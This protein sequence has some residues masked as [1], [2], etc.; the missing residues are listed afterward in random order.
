MTSAFLASWAEDGLKEFWVDSGPLDSAH[1]VPGDRSLPTLLGLLV[2][3]PSHAVG[4]HSGP[5]GRVTLK[6]QQPFIQLQPGEK[7]LTPPLG[8]RR[9]CRRRS[10]ST[11]IGGGG[12][13]GSRWGALA[14]GAALRSRPGSRFTSTARRR[15]EHHPAFAHA[16]A[17]RA[18]C[19]GPELW[20]VLWPVQAS[21]LLH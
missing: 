6:A 5:T 1:L 20:G 11:G 15:G 17:R 8:A 7:G 2:M 14:S 21:P 10:L 19:L 16:P 4:L 12:A 9:A 13:P 18:P 3:A